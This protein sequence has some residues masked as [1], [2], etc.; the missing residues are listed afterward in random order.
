[1]YSNTILMHIVHVH[2]CTLQRWWVVLYIPGKL[3]SARHSKQV[4]I[5]GI[6]EDRVQ[7]HTILLVIFHYKNPMAGRHME[8]NG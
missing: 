8:E 3:L 6:D 1:M 4:G 7:S 5:G 2:V